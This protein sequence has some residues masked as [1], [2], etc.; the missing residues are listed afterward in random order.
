MSLRN[1]CLVLG[2][3]SL[4]L[5]STGCRTRDGRVTANTPRRPMDVLIEEGNPA[6]MEAKQY[7][8][9]QELRTYMKRDLP[10]R[11]ARYALDV[12]MI[13]QRSTY[14]AAVDGRDLLV[15]HYDS[16]NPG[17]AAARFVV[18]YGAGAASLDI[19]LSLYQGSNLQLSWKDGCGTS[20]HWSRIVKKLD[21]NMGKKLQ[22]FYQ[23][24]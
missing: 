21:D 19:S 9:R 20:G 16:Y 12:R 17:S 10:R 13:D 24:R 14:N 6:D 2:C 4:V 22:T 5:L 15:V 1:G 8:F 11:L 3:L 18:G 23:Q 7:Q